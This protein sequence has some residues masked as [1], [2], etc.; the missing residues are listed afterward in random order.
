[1]SRL[2]LL[3]DD[4]K[5]RIKAL[6]SLAKQIIDFND[7]CAKL[8]GVAEVIKSNN[9][10]LQ[11]LEFEMQR[12]WK[13]EVN[14]NYHTWWLEHAACTCPKMDNKDPMF[15]GAGKIISSDCPIHNPIA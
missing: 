6:H 8:G 5:Q 7:Q 2:P 3:N 4:E 9:N 10:T 13:F 11:E 14:A 1:M 12:V 15:Y